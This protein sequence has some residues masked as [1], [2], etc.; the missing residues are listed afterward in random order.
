MSNIRAYWKVFAAKYPEYMEEF[1]SLDEKLDSL[2]NE[3][4]E[5]P[6]SCILHTELT[7][8]EK[9][10]LILVV[11]L[12]PERYGTSEEKLALIGKYGPAAV[13]LLDR[14]LELLGYK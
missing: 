4:I 12:L 8:Q 14:T 1:R 13:V 5:G 11:E 9:R 7:D 6:R 2:K 10:A 3:V